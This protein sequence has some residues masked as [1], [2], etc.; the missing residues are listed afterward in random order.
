MQ[1]QRAIVAP[2]GWQRSVKRFLALAQHQLLQARQ[3]VQAALD[4]FVAGQSQATL[5]SRFLRAPIDRL[6]GGL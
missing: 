5:G 3:R 2:H 6:E 4:G 1:S